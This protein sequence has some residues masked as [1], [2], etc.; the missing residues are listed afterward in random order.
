MYIEG[1]QAIIFKGVYVTTKVSIYQYDLG[2]KGQGN[3]FLKPVFGLKWE[4][5]YF[6]TEC[7]FNI[8]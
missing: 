2:V 8:I 5:L 3:I 7:V 1:S 6:W 4:L